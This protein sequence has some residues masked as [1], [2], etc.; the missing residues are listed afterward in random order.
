LVSGGIS[1]ADGFV[2][3]LDA[4]A[5]ELNDRPRRIH[6]YRTSAEAYAHLLNSGDALTA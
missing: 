5:A 6:G 4:T 2:G 3:E 1:R